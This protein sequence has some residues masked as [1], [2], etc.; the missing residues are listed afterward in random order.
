MYFYFGVTHVYLCAC[1]CMCAHAVGVQCPWR[2][3]EDIG[4]H[5]TGVADAHSC[6]VVVGNQDQVLSAAPLRAEP[7]L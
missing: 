4:S 3:E 7:F 1:D 5:G 2:L 6:C